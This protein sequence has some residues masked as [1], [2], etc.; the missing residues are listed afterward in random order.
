MGPRATLNIV[1]NKNSFILA[2][3][4]NSDLLPCSLV[5]IVTIEGQIFVMKT[6]MRID[7]KVGGGGGERG[8]MSSH[9]ITSL[10][11]ST[12]RL[13]GKTQKSKEC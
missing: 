5:A 13:L 11:N 1:E 8:S 10:R 9:P 3:F 2:G 6:R 7:K 12:E 4:R